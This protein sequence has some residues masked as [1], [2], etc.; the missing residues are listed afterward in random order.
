MSLELPAKPNLEHL[1][2]QAK[3]LLRQ[4]QQGESGAAARFR[5]LAPYTDSAD[6]KLADAQH[7]V[8]RDYGFPT[9]AKLKEHV[10]D[11]TRR[12]APAEALTAAVR[13]S[14]AERV[15]RLL[16]EH[17][18]LRASINE[19]LADYGAGMQAMLAAVQRSDRKTIEVLLENGADINARSHWWAG[20]VG[21]LDEAGE[22]F[23]PFLMERGAV[24]DEHAAARLGMFG[25]LRELVEANP[26][27]V[28][29]RGANGQT[30]LH[31][32]STTEIAEY[33]ADHGADL[34]ARDILHESTAAQHMLRVVQARHYRRDRQDIARLLVARG[35]QTDILMAAALGD[36]ALVRRHV[37]ADPDSIRM[38]VDEA[39]FPKRDP[40]SAGTIY[41][42]VFGRNRTPHMVARDFDRADVF[43]YLMEQSPEDVKL[44]QACELGDE[45]LFAGLLAARPNL[46]ET[47]TAEERRRLPDAAQNNN[48]AGVRLMLAA[49][50]P[51]D[52]R[53]EYDLTALGWA[54][55]H[56]NAEMVRD[57][58]RRGAQI[59]LRDCHE[60]TALGAALHG[61]ENSWHRDTGDYA[62]TVEALL[63]AGAKAPPVSDD[64]EA[65]PAVKET[66]RKHEE[67]R[68]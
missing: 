3:S 2:K 5:A 9:W 36:L 29:S 50:W 64:L 68:R 54:S 56:G 40:R 57:L 53:G 39:H 62:A 67:V 1:Q 51:V 58:L 47:L 65:S 17:A 11:L 33:L 42:H 22:D 61:S 35:C 48:L 34:D 18:E 49:G 23:A 63:A 46:V 10:E 41:E 24:A 8:A 55:W 6:L 27:A 14:D 30:T 13:A 44:A 38:R 60:Q 66:L 32:A 28:N 16:A 15:A 7:A 12:R 45:R 4:V 59:E 20:S 21:V 31:F 43:A 52:T 37:A 19:P 25:R 26:A